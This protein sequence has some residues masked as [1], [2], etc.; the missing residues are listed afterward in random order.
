MSLIGKDI[1]VFIMSLIGK[2]LAFFIMS[3]I[4]ANSSLDELR[5]EKSTSC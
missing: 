1:A 4:R 2:D 3:L 5:T